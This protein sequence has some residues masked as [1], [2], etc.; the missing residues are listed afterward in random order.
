MLGLLDHLHALTALIR[1]MAGNDIDLYRLRVWLTVQLIQAN[2]GLIPFDQGAYDDGI[3]APAEEG[4]RLAAELREAG[5]RIAVVKS[6][7]HDWEAPANR[8]AVRIGPFWSEDQTLVRFDVYRAIDAD[9]NTIDRTVAPAGPQPILRLPAATIRSAD[10]RSLA[11]ASGTVW[12][13]ARLFSAAAPDGLVG[14]RVDGGEVLVPAS[15]PD[16]PADGHWTLAADAE[17]AARFIPE[18]PAPAGPGDLGFRL[19]DAL[20]LRHDGTVL[21]EGNASLVTDAGTFDLPP[22]GAPGA[23]ADGIRIPLG[24]IGAELDTSQRPP[25]PL[26][27]RG[28]HRLAGAAWLLPFGVPADIAG[29][30]RDGG[31]LVLDLGDGAGRADIDGTTT[32]LNWARGQLRLFASRRLCIV[33]KA[34]GFG[35]MA[36]TGWDGTGCRFAIAAGEKLVTLSWSP[37]G[38]MSILISGGSITTA[39]DLPLAADGK[40]LDLPAPNTATL[41]LA[42]VADGNWVTT[43]DGM[44]SDRAARQLPKRGYALANLYLCVRGP[45][46]FLAGGH[47]AGLGAMDDGA[48]WLRFDGLSAEPTLPDP[49]ANNWTGQPSGDE[50]PLPVDAMVR[51]SAALRPSVTTGFA[52]VPHWPAPAAPDAEPSRVDAAFQ[53]RL[54]N[55]AHAAIEAGR[56]LKVIDLS[57]RAQQ[58]GIEI[59]RRALFGA[60][61]EA[62]SQL[63]L[64]TTNVRLFLLPQVQ[65]EP[66]RNMKADNAGPVIRAASQGM[67]AFAGAV[68]S[69]VVRALPEDVASHI[70][71]AQH[72]GAHAAALFSLPF[73]LRAFADLGPDDAREGPCPASVHIHAPRFEGD[74]VA[75]TQLRLEA[76]D[77]DRPGETPQGEA[78][79]MLGVMAS[80]TPENDPKDV[81]PPEVRSA[82]AARFANSVPLHRVDLSGYGLSCFSRWRFDPPPDQDFKGVTQV[83]FDAMIGR[84]AYEVIQLR[85]YLISAQ[86]RVVRTIILDRTNCGVVER[87]DSGWTPLEDGNFARYIPYRTG[88]LRGF[89]H[90]RNITILKRALISYPAP[91]HPPGSPPP[92]WRWQAVVYDADAHLGEP[93]GETVVPIRGHMGYIPL[94]PV[95]KPNDPIPADKLTAPILGVLF[96]A[97]GGPMGGPANALLKLGGTL[98]FHVTGIQSDQAVK[99]GGGLDFVVSVTGTPTLPRVGQWNAV[100]IASDGLV[101]PVDPH[102]G[103]PVIRAPDGTPYRF[104]E[105]ADAYSANAGRFGFLMDMDGGRLLFPAP[106]IN[107]DAPGKMTTE[108]PELADAY[109]LSQASG[110]LPPRARRLLGD[111]PAEFALSGA[112]NWRLLTNDLSVQLQDTTLAGTSKWQMKRA[113]DAEPQGVNL[114]VDTAASALKI[115]RSGRDSIDLDLPGLPQPLL[116][117]VGSFASELG[118]GASSQKPDVRF[119]PALQQLREIVDALDNFTQMP[120]PFDIDVSAAPGPTPAFDVRLRLRLRLPGR[121]NERID[122]GVGKFSGK[123]E[124]VGQLRAAL[125]GP[126]S[127]RL[128]LSFEGD[129]QQGIIPPAL[130]AGGYFRFAI[131]IADAAD[132]LV[133]L[134]FATTASIGGDLIKGLIELEVTVRYGYTLVP[135]TLEPGVLLG[136]EAR[137]KLLSGLVGLSFRTDVLARIRRLDASGALTDPRSPTVTIFAEINVIATVEVLWGLADDERELHTQFEQKL[138]LKPI[139]IL[140]LGVNPL[141]LATELL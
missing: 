104:S 30:A 126:A 100:R 20:V 58:F 53:N 95:S 99:P 94:A 45:C 60:S 55:A 31:A 130:F 129:L 32:A 48:A 80:V 74:L 29:E 10:G 84:T 67:P 2:P 109:A 21:I 111:T 41:G 135:Q 121:E 7:Y 25:A 136:L 18:Q 108:P 42:R 43:L 105:A 118:K 140:G 52:Q 128:L 83:R 122:I 88:L 61:L 47:G 9:W 5:E 86:C 36:L 91:D 125:S 33:P 62:D 81:L 134:A 12:I 57:S 137:A 8:N 3:I 107:P 71:R 93:G 27:L 38:E 23:A 89:S 63:S 132:P 26:R 106:Q 6:D 64:P 114:L 138:P 127:G 78:R 131:T 133:E 119:G 40:P 59:D 116:S 96:D 98:P 75:A 11:V 82:L 72:E 15:V 101:A 51:W 115:A 73:G 14:L 28:R 113:F 54:R 69:G 44:V 110:L 50:Q 19:P 56:G 141:L 37:G 79:T 76:Q 97:I 49:Y 92:I 139:V 39:L 70:V 66:V 65:W 123:F 22:S 120:L 4:E 103:L 77:R 85:S 112:S 102:R 17:W 124:A 87:H 68:A 90:I 1:C 35:T 16:L 13:A 24:S 34:S 117:L 46:R